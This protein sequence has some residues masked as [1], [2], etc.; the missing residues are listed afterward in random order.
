MS[1]LA[2]QLRADL[3]SAMKSRDEVTVATLRMAISAISTASVAGDSATELSDEQVIEVLRSE[4]KRRAEAA[5]VYEGAGRADRAAAERAELGVLEAYLPAAMDD[6]ALAAIVSEEVARVV[7]SGAVG[8]KAMGECVKAVRARVG[9]G[10]DGARV[11]AA[12][13]AE[14]GL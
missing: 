3:T 12:V 10:A 8:G 7:A 5:E 9:A 14:L 1:D 13:K 4:A 6:A 11:A 2:A